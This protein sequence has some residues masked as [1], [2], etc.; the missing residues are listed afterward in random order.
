ME[1]TEKQANVETKTKDQVVLAGKSLSILAH[2][3]GVFTLYLR[4]LL[5]RQGTK[6]TV[7]T[8]SLE[9]R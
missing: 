7:E 1:K 9:N 8:I 5:K 3:Y 6:Q 2:G 4:H